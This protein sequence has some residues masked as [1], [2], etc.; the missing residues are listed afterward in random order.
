MPLTSSPHSFQVPGYEEVLVE[1]IN[2]CCAHFE[3]Q[4]YVVPDEKYQ[5]LKVGRQMEGSG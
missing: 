2:L 5:L 4:T 3:A 1:T